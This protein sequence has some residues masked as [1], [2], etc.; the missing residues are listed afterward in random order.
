[1]VQVRER[2]YTVRELVIATAMLLIV[3]GLTMPSFARARSTARTSACLSNAKQLAL[4]VRM[5]VQDYDEVLPY[6]YHQASCCGPTW[7]VDLLPYLRNRAVFR[8][9][10]DQRGDVCFAD[11]TPERPDVDGHAWSSYVANTVH[12]QPGGPVPYF[13]TDP[14]GIQGDRS[15]TG[16]EYLDAPQW[17]WSA[18]SPPGWAGAW[19]VLA[20]SDREQVMFAHRSRSAMSNAHAFDHASDAGSRRHRGG[21]VYAWADGHVAWSRPVACQ[22]DLSA[23]RCPWGVVAPADA[24]PR[25]R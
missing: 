3:A 23:R 22:A 11:L 19:L 10:N 13:G 20:E 9:P 1:M 8:C 12:S 24:A 18:P 2:G 25:N 16:S 5:Y 17:A 15:L 7:R 6:A 21:S 14:L 4:A